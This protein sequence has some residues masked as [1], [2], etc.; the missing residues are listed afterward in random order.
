MIKYSFILIVLALPTYRLFAQVP[1]GQL[2]RQKA[3]TRVKAK[4]IP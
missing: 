4:S 3:D 1:T 2:L